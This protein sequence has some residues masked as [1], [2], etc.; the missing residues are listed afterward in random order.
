MAIT[1]L[2]CWA[3]IIG[4]GAAMMPPGAGAVVITP[5]FGVS[6]TSLSNASQVEGS[7]DTAITAIDALYSNA[8]SIPVLFEY[9]AGGGGGASTDSAVDTVSY[10]TYLTALTEDSSA[11]PGNTTL[12]T[13][14][15]NLP[16][17][18]SGPSGG[19]TVTAPFASLILGQSLSLCFS[20][21]GSWVGG[22]NGFY[23]AV[24]TV[25]PGGG[26]YYTP[27]GPGYSA[28]AVSVT[29]HEL[30]E[31]LG[32][33]GAGTTLTDSGGTP[34][35]FGPTD[36]YRFAGTGNCSG[37]LTGTYS[38]TVSS[39]AIA[40]YSIDG[41]KT[42]IVD[43][44]G[45]PIQFN[46]AGGGSDYGDFAD[47]DPNIQDAFV[48][49]EPVANYTQSSVEFQMMES[50]GYDAY[51]VPEPA[52]LSLFGGALAVFLCARRRGRATTV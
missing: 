15:S 8:G 17:A 23:A 14:V 35:I 9:D 22:C 26:G 2:A 25:S 19:V 20:G 34:G 51:S 5:G 49:G 30:N 10:S 24:V 42:A 21:S 28:T 45:N 1:R 3:A 46:Q 43:A 50:I 29:E 39:S 44:Q 12:A 37:T 13:A 47:T 11:N 48:P 6:I 18:G 36:F 27:A 7:I 52:S 16:S 38:Y 41:G 31:V 40:C 4:L 33:G 32:G